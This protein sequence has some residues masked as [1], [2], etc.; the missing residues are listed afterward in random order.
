M[1]NRSMIRAGLPIGKFGVEFYCH[2]TLGSTND[3]AIRLARQGAP[4]GTLV[5]ADEQKAG[6]GR[7]GRHWLTPPG[8]ALALSVVLRPAPEAVTGGGLMTLGSLAVAE[9]LET[10][11][12]RPRVKWPNDVLVEG[13]KLAGVLVEASWTEANLDFAVCGI[14][15]NVRPAS[16]PSDQQVDYP[17]TCVEA[18]LGRRIDRE[19][20]LLAILTALDRWYCK[21][22]SHEMLGALQERLAFARQRVTIQT[23]GTQEITG[24]VLGLA[25]DGRL[26]LETDGGEVM[27]IGAEAAHLRP[28]PT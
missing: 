4:E 13:R 16:V 7:A 21:I 6:R 28:L 18:A 22:G 25:P 17:A 27:L 10:E 15:V 20:L 19:K 23:V 9:A 8:A 26:R 11:G 5:V 12:L 2:R 24:R 1:L 14:G 3:E